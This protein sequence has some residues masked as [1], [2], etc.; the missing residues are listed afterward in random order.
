LHGAVGTVV[1]D[2]K[3][4]IK[5]LKA[6]YDELT[7]EGEENYEKIT[8]ID[9]KSRDGWE[10]PIEGVELIYYKVE[11]SIESPTLVPKNKVIKKM[12]VRSKPFAK[13]A[14][15]RAWAMKDEEGNKYVLKT[16]INPDLA[17]STR[18]EQLEVQCV[19]QH[20]AEKYNE[21]IKE[22]NRKKKTSYKSVFV[23]DTFL[24]KFPSS[25]TASFQF[26]GE[27]HCGESLLKG[28][29]R[30]WTNNYDNYKRAGPTLISFCHFSWSY[31]NGK[32]MVCDLQGV[33]DE[34]S[35][36]LTDP[37]IHSTNRKKYGRSNLGE[38]G[39]RGFFMNHSCAAVA[40]CTDL[41]LTKSP[42]QK[43]EEDD[44][45]LVTKTLDHLRI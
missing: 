5:N 33:A 23:C 18:M 26:S 45:L 27:S 12:Y 7:K 24:I 20:I 9:W 6:E 39:F 19:S 11:G 44:S 40:I 14:L 36:Q 43:E 41:S 21:K 22:I 30:K 38:G 35:Y 8:E 2:L 16:Y 17:T 37:A 32:L 3:E 13:G 28:V 34:A 29:Y 42:F 31:T 25:A 10:K 1:V 4:D 15:R